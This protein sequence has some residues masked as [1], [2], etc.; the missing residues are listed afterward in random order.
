MDVTRLVFCGQAPSRLGD[1]RP[2]SGP[3]GTR[4]AKLLNL[5]DYERLAEQVTLV[6]LIDEPQDKAERRGD[7]FDLVQAKVKARE[8]MAGWSDDPEP[9]VVLACGHSV[10]RCLT[11]R[12]TELFRGRATIGVGVWC[13]PHPSGASSYWNSR[14]N[15]DKAAI[16]LNRLVKQKGIVIA[17]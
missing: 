9:V 10:F 6:N 15:V 12:K 2:F 13:F 11:G 8:L 3:S 7:V 1:G 5:G 17:R 4:L 16:F 14:G